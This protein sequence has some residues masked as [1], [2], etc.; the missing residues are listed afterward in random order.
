[1]TY[2]IMLQRNEFNVAMNLEFEE[3]DY[4]NFVQSSLK[5]HPLW[6]ALRIYYNYTL[7]VGPNALKKGEEVISRVF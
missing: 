2:L 1:M 7:P 6:I 4:V 5:S 3:K